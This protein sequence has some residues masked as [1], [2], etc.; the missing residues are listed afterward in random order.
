[1][2]GHAT[3][4]GHF[5]DAVV[6]QGAP[7]PPARPQPALL[8]GRHDGGPVIVVGIHDPHFPVWLQNLFPHARVTPRQGDDHEDEATN[9]ELFHVA[10]YDR[11]SL[12]PILRTSNGLYDPEPS[13]SFAL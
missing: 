6:G 5:H 4:E 9:D 1:M 11:V 8:V 3:A 7:G 2:K 13:A 10:P 12:Q